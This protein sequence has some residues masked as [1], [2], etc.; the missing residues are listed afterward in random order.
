[1]KLRY[2]T[3]S[4][5]W[6]HE[7]KAGG[8][9]S[10]GFNKIQIRSTPSSSVPQQ[11]YPF[12]LKNKQGNCGPLV[13]IM[14]SMS[15]EMALAG[16]GALFKSLQEVLVKRNGMVVVF[17]PETVVKDGLTGVTFLPEANKW[18]PVKTPLPHLV[19]NRVPFRKAEQQQ[20]FKDAVDY[21]SALGIP[22][23]NPAFI[24]KNKLYSIFARHDQ[25]R[26][27][28][29]ESICVKTMIQLAAFL[30]KHQG[31]YLKPASSSK[32]IGIFRLRQRN[33]QIELESHS[34]RQVYPGMKEFWKAKYRQLLK[35]DYIA[36]KEIKPAAIGGKRFDF[37]VHAHDGLDGYEVT[38][39]GIR[40]SEKLDLT[41]HVPNGGIVLPYIHV[42]NPRHDAFFAWAVKEIGH[43][44]TE[45]LGYFGE[46]SLDAGLTVE[47]DYAI[48]EV[49]SKPMSFDE[50]QIEEKRII[51]LVDLFFRKSGF[52][53]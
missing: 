24:N 43:L 49:N 6:T 20:P 9:I 21:F 53:N 36:Q 37:R 7:A 40:Q 5:E 13:G 48:F 14:T 33:G 28:M 23:F 16:N 19:F 18:I 8:S 25:L 10:F 1:M 39:I 34:Q 30:E 52:S 11:T 46:F 42:K 29:P 50:S 12:T 32:G 3:E 26:K 31:I 38:G 47:G 4:K 2:H 44:L 15:K 35:H 41:T 22:F 51:A 27:L 45:E 17:P